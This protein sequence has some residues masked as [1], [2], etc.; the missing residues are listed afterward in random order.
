MIMSKIFNAI[1][2]LTI[3]TWIFLSIFWVLLLLAI[4]FYEGLQAK[5]I[6]T[7]ILVIS[8]LLF[9]F[10]KLPSTVPGYLI[11]YMVIPAILYLTRVSIPRNANF[12]NSVMLIAIAG[13][14]DMFFQEGIFDSWNI[15][16]AN[17]SSLLIYVEICLLAVAIF[18]SF[19]D[20]LYQRISLRVMITNTIYLLLFTFIAS[21]PLL[22]VLF[23]II[24]YFYL[25]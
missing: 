9:W 7:V 23:C 3:Q 19:H 25:E 16:F 21:N 8:T 12:K 14:L 17:I 10:G 15:G 24:Y 1:S 18:L 20:W 4:F 5:I 6:I 22:A 2:S 13:I 11:N